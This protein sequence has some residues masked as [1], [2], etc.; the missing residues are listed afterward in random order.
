MHA[1]NGCRSTP[2]FLTAYVLYS[3]TYLYYKL[4]ITLM[5]C[6]RNYQWAISEMRGTE[7][8]SLEVGRF[9]LLGQMLGSMISCGLAVDMVYTAHIYTRTSTLL[10]ED[11]MYAGVFGHL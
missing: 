5:S 2:A 1:E 4:S 11:I 10:F 3:E 9:L 7:C 8:I 6:C